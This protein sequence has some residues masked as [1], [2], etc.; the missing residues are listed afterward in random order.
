MEMIRE[1][2]Q[3]IQPAMSVSLNQSR[4]SF[5]SFGNSEHAKTQRMMNDRTQDFSE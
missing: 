2:T 4:N 1:N 3:V 5:N